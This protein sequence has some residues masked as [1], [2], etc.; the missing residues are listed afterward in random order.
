MGVL[1]PDELPQEFGHFVQD[2]YHHVLGVMRITGFLRILKGQDAS[3][4]AR[5]ILKNAV[6]RK[7]AL[8]KQ[9]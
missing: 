2:I 1:S 8:A 4:K 9:D 5:P 3:G 7:M 6:V